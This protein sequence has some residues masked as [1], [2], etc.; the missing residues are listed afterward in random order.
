MRDSACQVVYQKPLGKGYFRIGL[1]TT[2][3]EF[4]PGQFGMLEV[5][6]VGGILLRRP[7]S[8]ARQDGNTTEILYKVVGKG[9]QALSQVPEGASLKL[10]GPLGRGFRV[11][12][13]EGD[14]IG[15]AGGYGIAPFLEMAHQFQKLQNRDR[16]LKLYYGARTKRDL[17]YLPELEALGVEMNLSTEDGSTGFQGLVTELL[18]K[19]FETKKPM[20]IGS[21]GPMGLLKA[22]QRWAKEKDV[23]CEVSVEET[24]GCG[25]GVCLGCVVKNNEDHYVR[26]CVEGPVFM[27]DEIQL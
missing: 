21:C 25:V 8:L 24:M 5:P 10:L 4:I 12:Q 16:S 23:L 1:K 15:V 3:T 9:T 26:A 18:A 6:P 7:F 14:L 2:F 20:W 17:L 22:V 11:P 27:G 19:N 13:G